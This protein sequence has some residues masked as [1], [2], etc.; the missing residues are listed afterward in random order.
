MYKC[1]SIVKQVGQNV[2][3]YCIWVPGSLYTI[4]TASKYKL[5]KV[6]NKVSITTIDN[7]AAHTIY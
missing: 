3:N 2:N 7:K 5:Q 6:K 1:D 4:L